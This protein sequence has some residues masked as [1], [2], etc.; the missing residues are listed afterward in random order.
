M[1]KGYSCDG[2]EKFTRKPVKVQHPSSD[3]KLD[4]LGTEV[5]ETDMQDDDPDR[6]HYCQ[7]CM[8]Q[9]KDSL[10]NDQNED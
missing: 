8:E 2:C 10:E 9:M 6:E 5:S 3:K 7:K 1:T 4:Y